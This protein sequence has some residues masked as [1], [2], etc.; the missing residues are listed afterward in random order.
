MLS[1][2][3]FSS[4]AQLASQTLGFDF[5]PASTEIT[6]ACVDTPPVDGFGWNGVC[7][8]RP[9][10]ASF[11]MGYDY[12]S[13]FPLKA[14]GDT[15]LV[16][17][18]HISDCF[19][20]GSVS[21]YQ[22]NEGMPVKRGE[23][24][25]SAR[26]P[27]D[28]F[29]L[30]GS[31]RYALN[32]EHIAIGHNRLVT[33]FGVSDSQ[34]QV[35]LD[36]GALDNSRNVLGL[37][38]FIGSHLLVAKRFDDQIYFYDSTDWTQS[39]VIDGAEDAIVNSEGEI[40]AQRIDNDSNERPR[41]L[42]IYRLNSGVPEQI[43]SHLEDRG[44]V[45]R[46]TIRKFFSDEFF[47]EVQYDVSTADFE[48]GSDSI[49]TI[50]RNDAGAWELG[51]DRLPM[52]G[53]TREFVTLVGDSLI[54]LPQ[55]R[56]EVEFYRH[57]RL[58]GWMLDQSLPLPVANG[59]GEFFTSSLVQASDN[60]VAVWSSP[61]DSTRRVLNLFQEDNGIWTNTGE[62]SDPHGEVVLVT[63]DYVILN[64]DDGRGVLS[65]DFTSGAVSEESQVAAEQS[66]DGCDYSDAGSFNG[67]GW[68]PL[69]R[70]SCA[71]LDTAQTMNSNDCDYTDAVRNGGWGWDP[72]ARQS[73]EP[74][75]TESSLQA[76]SESVLC[77]DSDGDGWGWNSETLSS[78]RPVE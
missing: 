27:G 46:S 67:W 7:T 44:N 38:E 3:L 35:V 26:A 11:F 24:L 63:D 75:A 64:A 30:G 45:S 53:N 70:E 31:D 32:D 39:Q 10:P 61:P 76:N 56:A 37:V 43:F 20:S 8:C 42:E 41:W 62:Y 60:R 74:L 28:N 4:S 59:I 69:T 12:H 6:A 16:S 29:S 22:L 19:G 14:F 34:E 17:A 18:H 50:F 25:S 52:P 78:C 48:D 54:R 51:E 68:N 72:V 47:V 1:L 65:I 40:S 77:V 36:I 58:R 49:T 73:C 13:G 33:V 2:L 66:S 23:L 55:G 9:T 15:F 21:V 57:E 5:T 71:P